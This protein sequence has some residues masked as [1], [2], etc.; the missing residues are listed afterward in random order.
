MCIFPLLF[1]VDHYDLYVYNGYIQ[2][3]KGA[4]LMVNDDIPPTPGI[5]AIV[6]LVNQH[7]YVGSAKNLRHRFFPGSILEK[8][9]CLLLIALFMDLYA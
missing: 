4:L 2:M 5:Y 1:T 9:C 8:V 7:F 6:N 3:N